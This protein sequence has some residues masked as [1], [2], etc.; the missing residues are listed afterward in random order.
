MTWDNSGVCRGNLI[1]ERDYNKLSDSE[2]EKIHVFSYD[3]ERLL[4][5][6]KDTARGIVCADLGRQV[7]FI[8]FFSDT[9]FTPEFLKKLDENVIKPAFQLP[10]QNSFD[11]IKDIEASI[12]SSNDD[13]DSDPI[14]DANI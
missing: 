11:D 2:K 3:G 1:S 7:N 8:E 5:Q 6:E 10:D 14:A 4:C 9:V 12:A 13:S